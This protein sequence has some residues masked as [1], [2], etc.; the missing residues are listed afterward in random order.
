MELNQLPVIVMSLVVFGMVLAMGML[1]LTQ[2]RTVTLAI[3]GDDN[4][5]AYQ[6][7]NSTLAGIGSIA[8]WI[9]MIVISVIFA[10]I[11][12]VIAWAFSRK[13]A[14]GMY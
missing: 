9:P 10:I 6:A 12:G 13:N 8:D 14:G 3:T 2:A 5:T 4:S 1:V 7:I 11:F